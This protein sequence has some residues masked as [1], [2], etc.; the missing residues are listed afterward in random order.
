MHSTL[1]SVHISIHKRSVA[2]AH[3]FDARA[4]SPCLPFLSYLPLFAF[5]LYSTHTHFF[6]SLFFLAVSRCLHRLSSFILVYGVLFAWLSSINL[7]CVHSFCCCRRCCCCS[8]VAVVGVMVYYSLSF[9]RFHFFVCLFKFGQ[10][11][12]LTLPFFPNDIPFMCKCT[13]SW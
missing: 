1:R 10:R 9:F 5:T 7:L 6:I 3:T 2:L 11:S 8:C 4:R 12:Q 13:H